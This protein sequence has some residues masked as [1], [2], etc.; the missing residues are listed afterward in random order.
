M[1]V[2]AFSICHIRKS[3]IELLYIK[4]TLYGQTFLFTVLLKS[5]L[6]P[7][8]SFLARRESR[9]QRRESWLAR[10]ESRLVRQESR[11]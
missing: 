10:Q 11:L 6:P 7:L 8:V 4:T 3:F 5:K 2:Q 9:L 1:Y